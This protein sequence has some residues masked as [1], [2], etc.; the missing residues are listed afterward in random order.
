MR[1]AILVRGLPGAGKTTE[2]RALGLEDFALSFDDVRR[3]A[4]AAERTPEGAWSLP[5]SL[6]DAVFGLTRRLAAER[7]A[8]GETLVFEAVNAGRK[9]WQWLRKLAAEEGYRLLVLDM[10]GVP[11]EEALRRNAARP[12]TRRVPEAA[13]RAFARR[14]RPLP[15]DAAREPARDP[16]VAWRADGG[17]RAE[18]ADFLGEPPADLSAYA[19]IVHVGDLQGCATVLTEAGLAP[20]ALDANS[21]HL[22]VGDICDRGA[23]NA[24]AFAYAEAIVDRPNVAILIGNHELHLRRWARGLPPVSRT[25]AEETLPELQAAGVTPQRA[26]ALVAKL[27]PLLVYTWRGHRVLA[28]HAGLSGLPV[29]AGSLELGL[30]LLSEAQCLRGTGGYGHDVDAAWQASAPEPWVQVHGHRNKAAL[31]V[32][33]APLSFNLEGRVEFGGCL[34]IAELADDGW[35]TREIPNRIVRATHAEPWPR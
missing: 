31:P 21:F 3:V 4:G 18:I 25:F 19:R 1:K 24:A 33:A 8:R 13:V 14:M 17:H 10:A 22:F 9:D 30:G 23:E 16:V 7:M 15:G 27:R 32:R 12:E 26:G 20:D 34:R 28:T 2:I 5:Q 29:Y 6:N 35:A 11:L